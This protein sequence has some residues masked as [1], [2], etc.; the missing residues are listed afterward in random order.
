MKTHLI[1]SCM[2]YMS[3]LA[4]LEF[5]VVR[6]NEYSCVW[7][8]LD[9]GGATSSAGE[10][11]IASTLAQP[12]AGWMSGGLFTL[13]GGF[14]PAFT[15]DRFCPGDLN[16][17]LVVNLDDLAQLLG[18][19]GMT[20][21]ASY[22]MGDLDG[23]GD[24][25][26]GDLVEMLGHY[27]TVCTP[28][29]EIEIETV[30]VGH[31][32]NIG[33]SSGGGMGQWGP[34]RTC[35]A[36]DYP[37]NIGKYEVTA[38]QYA[39]FLNAVAATD[40]YGLYN[41]EMWENEYGC[42][43]TR[44]GASGNYTYNVTPDRANRP[45]NYVSWGDAVRFANWLHNGQPSGVQDLNTTED[46][47]YYLNG[48]IS[49]VE[50]MT[51]AR[52]DNWKWAITSE[53]EWYKAAYHKNDGPSEHYFSYPTGDDE[54]PGNQLDIPDTGNNATYYRDGYGHTI[55]D[56]YWRTEVG[57]HEN[58]YSPYGTFDQGGNVSEWNESVLYNQ[59]RGLRGGSYLGCGSPSDQ[60][61]LSINRSATPSPT[62]EIDSI[63]F[64]V[65][66]AIG[67]LR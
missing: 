56:P 36:V 52:K 64:R 4:L 6:A 67:T 45:V 57:A 41:T 10:Y 27:G 51:V 12:D 47:A 28:S 29:P 22:E 35:G 61:M 48:A 38:G 20:V 43:I 49:D 21:G 54:V 15:V 7:Y 30:C 23:D 24:V 39:A 25:D 2:L 34:P 60:C 62:L 14:W 37:F 13:S 53:D 55:G 11:L 46:G 50:L 16:S 63:G 9:A 19:Y 32:G 17:D 65:S 8:T 5:T 1:K 40:T 58:S 59:F 44:S 26:L 3:L 33:E 66:Q 31:P 42:K 18:H